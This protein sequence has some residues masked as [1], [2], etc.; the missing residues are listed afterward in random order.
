MYCL[1]C[2]KKLRKIKEDEYFNNWTR[3]YH[4]SC[5]KYFSFD[6]QKALKILI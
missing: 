1:T 5:L 3:K 4:K 2:K 6:E